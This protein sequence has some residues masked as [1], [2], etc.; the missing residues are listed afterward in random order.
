MVTV[1]KCFEVG[2]A[3]SAVSEDMVVAMPARRGCLTQAS[4]PIASHFSQNSL[5]TEGIQFAIF[6]FYQF[7]GV[8]QLV[9]RNLAKVEAVSSNLIAR[10]ISLNYGLEH[11]VC[12]A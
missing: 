2:T 1:S 5:L 4:L 7:A 9:E 6:I 3:V 10:S 8:A 12:L 11:T